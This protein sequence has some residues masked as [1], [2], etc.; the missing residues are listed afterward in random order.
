MKEI[1]E[2]GNRC[3]SYPKRIFQLKDAIIEDEYK[4]CEYRQKIQMD[5]T[6]SFRHRVLI[7][8]L[9]KKMDKTSI[10]LTLLMPY[11]VSP[12]SIRRKHGNSPSFLFN[13]PEFLHIDNRNKNKVFGK[14]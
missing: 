4:K 12:L 11:L 9:I 3:S 10:R 14:S 5:V 8:K 6:S 1:R 2:L 13:E 7:F